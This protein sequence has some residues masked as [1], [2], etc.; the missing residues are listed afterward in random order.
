M[1]SPQEFE[2]PVSIG[3][4]PALVLITALICFSAMVIAM[5][6]CAKA[7]DIERS[8]SRVATSPGEQAEGE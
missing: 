5:A 4:W 8:K 6:D 3:K 2:G 7:S 1:K